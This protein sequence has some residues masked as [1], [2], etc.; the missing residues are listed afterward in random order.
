MKT[1]T[2][3]TIDTSCRDG[4]LTLDGEERVTTCMAMDVMSRKAKGI[5]VGDFVTDSNGVLCRVTEVH[6]EEYDEAET[7]P[8]HAIR[9]SLPTTTIV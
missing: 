5:C 9:D 3:L 2:K 4:M 1:R 6:S 7:N 8:D